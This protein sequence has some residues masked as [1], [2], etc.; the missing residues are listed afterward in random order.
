MSARIDMTGKRPETI[1]DIL[2]SIDKTS[3]SS[4][5]TT[6]DINEITTNVPLFGEVPHQENNNM[7]TINGPKVL[8]DVDMKNH[9]NITKSAMNDVAVITIDD[10]GK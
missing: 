8:S 1:D 5:S 10:N 2:E 4:I 9:I 6:L 3:E 7:I